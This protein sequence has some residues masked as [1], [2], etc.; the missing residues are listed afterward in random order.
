[1]LD[2]RKKLWDGHSDFHWAKAFASGG[3][4]LDPRGRQ[5]C[6]ATLG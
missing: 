5:L 3:V 6:G 2:L 1:M 4:D